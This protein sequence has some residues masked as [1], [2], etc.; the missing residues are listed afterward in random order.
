MSTIGCS[1]STMLAGHP[2][3]RRTQLAQKRYEREAEIQGPPKLFAN[4]SSIA[5]QTP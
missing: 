5:K 4:V 1:A 2:N 3:C